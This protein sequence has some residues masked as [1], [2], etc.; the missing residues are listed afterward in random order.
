MIIRNRY[1]TLVFVIVLSSY[2]DLVQALADDQVETCNHPSNYSD[3]TILLI[4]NTIIAT[5]GNSVS[6]AFLV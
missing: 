1:F 4:N 3:F 2:L 5:G 6:F